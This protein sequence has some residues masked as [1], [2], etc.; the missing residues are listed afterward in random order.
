[1]AIV[2]A[3]FNLMNFPLGTLIG[4]YT[5]WVLFQEAASDYFILPKIGLA[6]T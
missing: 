6:R 2:L 5:L 4:I 1:M 3:I